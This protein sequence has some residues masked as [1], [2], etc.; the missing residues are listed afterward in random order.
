MITT[1]VANVI[2]GFGTLLLTLIM[3]VIMIINLKK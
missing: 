2:L 3:V 1:D